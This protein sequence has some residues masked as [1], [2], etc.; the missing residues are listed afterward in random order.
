MSSLGEFSLIARYFTRPG[1]ERRGV[2]DDCALIDAGAQTLALTSDML[3]E[4]VHFFP[5]A[6][7]RD[8]G[9]KA[10]AVNLSDLAAAGARPRCFLLDLALPA[11]DQA[12]L[13][14]FSDG[15]FALA[16]LHD[17]ELVGGD[18][19][20]SPAGRESPGPI[21]IAITAVGEVA[22]GAFRG[23][24]GAQPG[25]DIWVSG[26]LGEAALA[27]AV[28]RLE[29]GEASVLP[30]GFDR[31]VPPGC[32]AQRWQRDLLH[33]RLRM[34]CPEPRVALGLA[35]ARL[36]TAAIDVSDGLVGDLGHILER[37]GVGAELSWPDIPA[38]CVPA[39][40]DEALRERLVLAGGDD[41]ELL[42][43]ARARD[44]AAVAA[45]ASERVPL[46]RIGHISAQAGLRIQGAVAGAT[47]QAF[48]HFRS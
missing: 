22:P 29:R 20:R 4:G 26:A 2:G 19:V 6:D 47:L 36:A 43:T 16:R 48:D 30:A 12:W 40:L 13:G 17:C 34:D 44:R 39:G 38:G 37:S 32:T 18:T 28:R 35:L 25:D 8:L 3:V 46:S 42:F 23:R 9:H 31:D 24:D 21:V 41:Y 5:Q 14:A 15:L 11:A 10:L 7:A 45:L 1:R 33:C 27:L